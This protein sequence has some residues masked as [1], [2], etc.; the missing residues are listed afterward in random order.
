VYIKGMVMKLG[1]TT[2]YHWPTNVVPRT[3]NCRVYIT[4]GGAARWP[5]S[6]LFW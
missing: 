4:L 5:E 3:V 1:Q 2:E 6:A